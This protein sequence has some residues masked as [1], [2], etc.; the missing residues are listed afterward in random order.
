M[1]LPKEA[2]LSR[3]QKE[4]C[5]A[6]PE[7]TAI[8]VG[9]PG[10]GKTVVA[11][12]RMRNLK[13]G[14][15]AVVAAMHNRVLSRYAGQSQTFHTWIQ[16]WWRE[17]TRRSLPTSATREPNGFQHP[18]FASAA[19][20]AC[21]TLKGEIRSKGHWGHLILDEAQDFDASAHRFLSA[22]Q[23]LSF[24]DLEPADRP[25]ILILADENQR[26]TQ[27][28]STVRDL[29]DAYMIPRDELYLLKRNYR[30]TREIA[31]FAAQFFNDAASGIPELP[32]RR[33]DVP[34]IVVTSSLDDAVDRIAAHA[35]LHANEEIGVLVHYEK[36]RRKLYN[37]LTHRLRD[38]KIAVQTY[39]SQ[40]EQF[41]NEDALKFDEPGVTV[42][43][44]A[45]SKGLE[46]DSVFLPELQSYPMDP[47][48][49]DVVKMHLDVM[50][51]RARNLLTALLT[52]PGREADFWKLLLSDGDGAPPYVVE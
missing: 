34:R 39:S 45:S 24:S 13:Q 48:T 26:I 2:Q 17:S 21:S 35:R 44:Y 33:G 42:L 22:V 27:K 47:E 11:L 43:C 15:H 32:E 49:R 36:T 51:S 12:F 4:V 7:G 31:R 8:V 41:R 6:P 9:P 46:F 29:S 18:D 19:N 16:K 10:S 20:L 1:R 50:A 52:D 38:V 23:S 25:S 30:N 37:K 3:E 28:N 5:F 14:K 40:D